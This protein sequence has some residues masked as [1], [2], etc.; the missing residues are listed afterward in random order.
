MLIT[1]PWQIESFGF[2]APEAFI[3]LLI[4]PVIA[5][6]YI[7]MQY[8]RRRY[9]VRYASVSLVREAVGRGPGVRRH[10]PAALY[11]LALGAMVVALAR[12]QGVLDTSFTTGTVVLAIDVSGSM[13]AED[14]QP[15]RME[16]TKEAAKQF[17]D[18]QPRGVQIG[19]VAF[20]QFGL[21]TQEPTRDKREVNQA[22]DRLQPKDATN[23]GGGLQAALDA[24][25]EAEEIARPDANSQAQS[26]SRPSPTPTPDAATAPKP[27]PASIVLVSD[28]EANTG[29]P[30][31]QVADEAVAA[32]VKVYTIGIGTPEGTYVQLRGRS[33]FTRLDEVT[34]REIAEVTGG[35][36]LS[37]QSE[38]ELS[39]VYN[40]LV[41]HEEVE[42]EERDLT[43]YLTGI[44]LLFSI[45]AG[46]FSLAWFNRLP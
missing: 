7:W 39:R 45:I 14:V 41:F 42:P 13:F 15:N 12:P 22:I 44:G 40:E 20:S 36:Y 18:N 46:A 19:V 28:G 5:A 29:P 9:A 4:L 25:Y 27:P 23:I 8:R 30:P 35:T 31:L 38:E 17:V 6:A 11:L 26:G 21:I 37:A 32:G 24:I 16:A 3:F 2:Q 10:I 1:W 34:L 33:Q 43:Y